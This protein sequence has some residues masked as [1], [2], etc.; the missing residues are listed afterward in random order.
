M[1]ITIVKTIPPWSRRAEVVL[2]QRVAVFPALVQADVVP[3]L[4]V[5]VG[6]RP[7]RK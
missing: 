4:G 1:P 6:D 7:L 2:D 3:E 5:L